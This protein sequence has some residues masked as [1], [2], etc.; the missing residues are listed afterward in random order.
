MSPQPSR[1]AKWL[2]RAVG[3]AADGVVGSQTLEAVEKVPPAVIINRICD[4]RL[5][6]LQGLPTWGTFG[7]GWKKRVEGVRKEALAMAQGAA[8]VQPKPAPAPAEPP[9]QPSAAVTALVGAVITALVALAAYLGVDADA[10]KAM[11]Q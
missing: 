10:L 3:A 11:I 7:K 4:D 5:N 8:P 6:F 2:Q 9:T 1:A